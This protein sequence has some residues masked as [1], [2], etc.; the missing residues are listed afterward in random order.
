M[1]SHLPELNIIFL[2]GKKKYIKKTTRCKIAPVE[3]KYKK[4]EKEKT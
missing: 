3:Q 4:E 2:I 1:V